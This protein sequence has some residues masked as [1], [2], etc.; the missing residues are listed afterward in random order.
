MSER[1]PPSPAFL[2]TFVAQADRRGAVRFDQFVALAL[3]D[4]HCGY[5][6][7]NRRRVGREPGTDFFT[8]TSSGPL[9]GELI[10]SA[11]ASL[12]EGDPAE[13]TFVEL[14]AEPDR[15]IL[16]DAD[17]PFRASDVRHLGDPLSLKGN[18]VVFS[19]E[20]LDAQPFRR[21]VARGQRWIERGVMW[22][23]EQLTET[24]WADADEPWLPPPGAD[25]TY[26]D[27][28]R[29]AAELVTALGRESWR[30][31]F[32]AVDYGKSL[33]QL[34]RD[35]PSGTARAYWR[36]TQHNDLLDRPGEQDLTVHICWDWIDQALRTAA[37]K[38]PQLESQEA[39][40]MHHAAAKIETL[41][42]N[43]AGQRGPRTRSLL[44]LLHP[45]NLGQA[46]QVMWAHRG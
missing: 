15:S 46:F 12:L 25:G 29:A 26:F 37:F 45:A 17:H 6:T 32:V 3:Y 27:A 18:L 24:D 36:H 2:E 38:E 5:Y 41:L 1:I 20:L 4:P 23:G 19:N 31:L 44:Q 9:F 33:G 39:F 13:T 42:R 40:L 35:C 16:H 7:A 22:T 34:A 30:G 8:S 28:P 10:A 21:F 14:G 11:C 43:D